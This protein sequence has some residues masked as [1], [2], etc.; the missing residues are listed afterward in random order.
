MSK[1]ECL[2]CMS[3]ISADFLVKK[4][5]YITC[6]VCGTVMVIASL[7]PPQLDW[8]GVSTWKPEEVERYERKH[9]KE[10]RFQDDDLEAEVDEFDRWRERNQKRGKRFRRL[11]DDY[12][13]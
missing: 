7:D 8:M 4:G 11:D 5:E 13:S 3:E 10:R 9:K 6:A 2:V 1:F 12:D